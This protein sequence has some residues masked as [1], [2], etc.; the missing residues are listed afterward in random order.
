M[1]RL[2]LVAWVALLCWQAIFIPHQLEVSTIRL[3]L[4]MTSN[5]PMHLSLNEA[6]AWSLEPARQGRARTI[7]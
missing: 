2:A 1:T 7:T 5:Q 3:H 6:R 4:D